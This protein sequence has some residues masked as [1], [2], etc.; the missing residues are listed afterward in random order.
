MKERKGIAMDSRLRCAAFV[1]ATVMVWAGTVH[2]TDDSAKGAAR[3]LA[4]AAKDDFDAGKFED[5]GSKFQR[6]YEIAKVPTLA[7]WAARSL[8][9][10][11]KMVAASELYRQAALLA[12]NDLWVGNSQQQAQA[13]AEKELAELH[14]RIP[15]LRIRVEG[16]VANDVELTVDGARIATALLGIDLPTD[17]GKRHVVGKR[18]TDVV[19]QTVDLAESERKETLMKFHP[20]AP[21]V[22]QPAK[23]AEVFSAPPVVVQPAASLPVTN[24]PPVVPIQAPVS[25]ARRDGLATTPVLSVTETSSSVSNSGSAQ[26][27][28][29][30]VV[31]GVG[32]AGLLTGA[33]TGIVV[34]SNTSLRSDCPNGGCASSKSGSVDTYNLMRNIS[35]AGFIVGGVGVAVGVSLLLWTPRHESEPRMALWFGPSSAG[36]KGAF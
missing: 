5:A 36:V 9:K 32:A 6:A 8:V 11:G 15:R 13:D 19:E 12:P 29:G 23:P 14:P 31:A 30:W 22:A 4:N 18:G 10:R 28:W 33:V 27:T 16:A 26:R 24:A 25:E 1:L 7:V 21:V 3:E 20:V 35:T 34:M 2:A 17:P